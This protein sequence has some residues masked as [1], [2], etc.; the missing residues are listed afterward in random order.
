[1]SMVEKLHQTALAE[2]LS[3]LLWQILEPDLRERKRQRAIA[4]LD[5]WMATPDD[6]G[7]EWWAEFDRF[8][9]ANPFSLPE[10]P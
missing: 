10:V 5:E 8:L 6:L 9:Q 1:M 4:L 7:E 3:G 2:S